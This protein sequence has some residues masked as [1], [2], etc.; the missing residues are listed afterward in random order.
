MLSVTGANLSY[1]GG[2]CGGVCARVVCAERNK[3]KTEIMKITV[4]K[5]FL[6]VAMCPI[7]APSACL[8]GI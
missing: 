3:K 4:R 2:I 1:V 8:S 5:S 7:L 6:C